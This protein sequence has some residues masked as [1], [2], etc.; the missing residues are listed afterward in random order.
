MPMDTVIRTLLRILFSFGIP[1]GIIVGSIW[2]FKINRAYL[3]ASISNRKTVLCII[4]FE[5]LI[6]IALGVVAMNI[7]IPL[8]ERTNLYGLPMI[9]IILQKRGDIWIDYPNPLAAFAL[10]VNPMFFLMLIQLYGTIR[11]YRKKAI[12]S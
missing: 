2:T 8:D 6:G 5:I 12:K 9:V 10:I 3:L 11:Y 1:L 7:K 4:L